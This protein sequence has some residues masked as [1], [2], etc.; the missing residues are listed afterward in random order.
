MG[1]VE[2]LNWTKQSIKRNNKREKGQQNKREGEKG[3]SV[4][5]LAL[6][7]SCIQS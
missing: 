1:K 2:D 5:M 4:D 7:R 3:E 6:R